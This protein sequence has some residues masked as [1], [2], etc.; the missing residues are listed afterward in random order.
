MEG[1]KFRARECFRMTSVG[2]TTEPQANAVLALQQGDLTSFTDILNT[3]DV[4][5]AAGEAS[6][7][8]NRPVGEAARSLVEQVVTAGRLDFLEVLVLAGA[9]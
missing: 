7:W 5:A 2:C 8:I 6:H 3:A 4:E 9:R 1:G